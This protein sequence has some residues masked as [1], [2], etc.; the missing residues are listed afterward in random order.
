MDLEIFPKF[1]S[2][3]HTRSFSYVTMYSR[4]IHVHLMNM[5]PQALLQHTQ[6][7]VNTFKNLLSGYLRSN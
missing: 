5:S 4:N 7:S 3:F 6:W 1:A 2:C